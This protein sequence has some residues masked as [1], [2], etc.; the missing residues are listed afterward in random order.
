[1]R[2]EGLGGNVV[3]SAVAKVAALDEAVGHTLDIKLELQGMLSIVVS[4]SLWVFDGIRYQGWGRALR[5]VVEGSRD[6]EP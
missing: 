1:M 5:V 4:M 3:G 6:V 2:V